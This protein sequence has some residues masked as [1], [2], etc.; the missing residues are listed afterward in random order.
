MGDLSNQVHDW[1][2]G[3]LPSGLFWTIPIDGKAI[4][5]DLSGRARFHVKNLALPDYHDFGNAIS[6][7]PSS[8]PGHV[9]FDVR[10]S[11]SEEVFDVQMQRGKVIVRGPLA[12]NGITME[13]GQ[14]LHQHPAHCYTAHHS[15]LGKSF[16]TKFIL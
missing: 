2:P 14:R 6:P 3:I 16:P 4:Q 1:N 9:S 11:G 13:A 15:P 8:V 5:A 7:S 12:S 10:W